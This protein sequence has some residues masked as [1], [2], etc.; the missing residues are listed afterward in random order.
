[1]LY[2]L[3]SGHI[4]FPFLG[5]ILNGLY[6]GL[7][8][9]GLAAAGT[10][11]M[12]QLVR[13]G[14]PASRL[15]AFSAGMIIMVFPLGIIGSRSANMFYYPA[16]QW[17]VRFFVEQFVSGPHQTFHGALI[18]PT[19]FLLVLGQACGFEKRRLA[20]ALFASIPLGHAV[21]RCGCLLVGCCWGQPIHLSWLGHAVSFHHPVPLYAMVLNLCL[22]WGLKTL[23]R[24]I[25]ITKETGLKMGMIPSLYLIGYGGVRFVLEGIRTE[26]VVGKGMTQAQWSMLVFIGLGLIMGVIMLGASTQVPNHASRLRPALNRKAQ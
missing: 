3:L 17:S 11:F 20:D 16:D 13:A 10:F 26:T 15:R 21:G 12:G 2:P 6:Y 7:I 9:L 22:F 18:L 24:R 4:G 23:Y 25:Y 1:M 19:L 5:Y 8:I 14:Y